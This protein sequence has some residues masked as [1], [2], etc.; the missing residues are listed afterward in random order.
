MRISFW[1]IMILGVTLII[2]K[3]RPLYPTKYFQDSL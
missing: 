2:K 3:D 1:P